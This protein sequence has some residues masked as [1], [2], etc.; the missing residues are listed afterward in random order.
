MSARGLRALLGAAAVCACSGEKLTPGLDEPVRVSGAQF[1]SGALPGF[2]ALSEEERQAGA[3]EQNPK[4]TG[5]TLVNLDVSPGQQ[6]KSMQGHAG[7]DAEAVALRFRD[8][9]S[10]Y[11]VL[12]VGAPDLTLGGEYTW[13]ARVDFAPKIPLG[14]QVLLV[15]AMDSNGRAGTQFAIPFCFTSPIGDKSVCDPTSAPPAAVVSLSWDASVDL[16]LHVV[17]PGGKVVGSK[18]PSTSTSSDGTKIDIT[19]PG[20]GVLDRDSVHD[21]VADGINRE[22]LIFRDKPPA[23]TYLV[24]TNLYDA[25][26][27]PAVRFDLKLYQ[28]AARPDGAQH[29]E[30]AFSRSGILLAA[31]ANAGTQRGLFV[32]YFTVN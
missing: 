17:T 20:T 26:G 3:Q 9:G 21:C 14:P 16:D 24:Y 6:G 23:G 29:L 2:P 15:V 32:T 11:W 27:L 19:V 18:V 22:N 28:S 30:S 12:P 25:C 5:L 4:I 31:D 13:A 10:G 8:L 1:R 7:T